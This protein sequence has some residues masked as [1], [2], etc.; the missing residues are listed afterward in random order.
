MLFC[1]GGEQSQEFR[2]LLWSTGRAAGSPVARTLLQSGGVYLKVPHLN[3][4]LPNKE[5]FGLEVSALTGGCSEKRQQG[6]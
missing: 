5:Y 3:Q 1:C 2:K 6:M 4:M